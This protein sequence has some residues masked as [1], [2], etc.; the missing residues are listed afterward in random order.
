[1]GLSR[2]ALEQATEYAKVRET[3]GKPIAEYQSIQNMLA[4]SL[5][6][7]YAARTMSLDCARR[8]DEGKDVRSEMAMIKLYATNMANRVIDRVIQIH[9]GMGLTNELHFTEA[10]RV[11]RTIRIAD[12]TDEIR[13]RT[14]AKE[15]LA[16]RITL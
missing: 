16:G 14:V 12:G 6:E 13:R 9:G 7:L 1:V 3:F 15:L 11:V 2:W 8:A 10:Y 5:V 4:D